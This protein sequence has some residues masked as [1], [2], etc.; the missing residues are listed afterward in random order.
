VQLERTLSI[1]KDLQDGSVLS[2]FQDGEQGQYTLHQT[3]STNT[4]LMQDHYDRVWVKRTDLT[5][6]TNETS[7]VGAP[8]NTSS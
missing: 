3:H 8:H 4:F 2:V 5:Y 7:Q 1:K 6:K